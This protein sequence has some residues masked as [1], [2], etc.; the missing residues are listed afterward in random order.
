MPNIPEETHALSGSFGDSNPSVVLEAAAA[1]AA[2]LLS[3]GAAASEAAEAATRITEAGGMETAT[4]SAGYSDVTIYWTDSE[5][6]TYFAIRPVPARVFD[7]G[8]LASVME[9]VDGVRSGHVR[10]YEASRS[11]RALEQQR[12]RY[13]WWATRLATGA[14]GS[15]ASVLFGGGLFVAIA[16]FLVNL[17][18][19][20]LFIV[21]FRRGWPSFFVQAV[22]GVL[23]IAVA[24]VLQAIAPETSPAVVVV[25]VII[26]SLAG[27]TSTG[28]V[29]DAITGWYINA[30]G[31]IFEGVTNT[32]G[33]VAGVQFGLLVVHLLGLP[34]SISQNVGI[35]TFPLPVVLVAAALVALGFG[36]ASQT[37]PLAFIPT[38][39]LAELSY[40]TFN[41]VIPIAGAIWGAAGAAFL[42]G[43]IAV[44]V[45]NRLRLPTT[46]VATCAILPMLP[47]LQLYQG[48]LELSGQQ[49]RPDSSLVAAV[50]TAL[51]LAAGT[52]FGEYCG[53]I[54]W[55]AL[56]VVAGRSFVPLFASP[57]RKGRWESNRPAR[58]TGLQRAKSGDK[59]SPVT[60]RIEENNEN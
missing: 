60:R 42:A 23:A 52:S 10:P 4:T 51:A 24:A 34:L 40:A 50:G 46:A 22:V 21:L 33:L 15:M 49:P 38:A 37:P 13:P 39:L 47:G 29:Q 17:V 56:R 18:V 8:R 5:E 41:V 35:G 9:L 43:L 32:A 54:V 14:A 25:A 48:L 58:T 20:W 27:M 31:R 11:V 16:A 28:A 3:N 2:A 6:R 57:T 55:R 45:T 19:D 1:T 7:Y 53:V 26:V 36:I 44:A 12:A 30:A 59:G